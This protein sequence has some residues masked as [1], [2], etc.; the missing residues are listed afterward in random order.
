MPDSLIESFLS[1]LKNGLTWIFGQLLVI[2]TAVV[3]TVL[4]AGKFLLDLITDLLPN[5]DYLL[6]LMAQLPESVLF[7]MKFAALDV[8]FPL[9]IAAYISR[10]I[11]RRIPFIG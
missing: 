5:P 1:A 4:L 8:G 2:K 7:L 10:F 11:I 3:S 6:S 9:V